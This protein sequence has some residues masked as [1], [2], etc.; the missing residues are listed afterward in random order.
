MRAQ[1]ITDFPDPTIG[2]NGQP[3]YANMPMPTDQFK[4]AVQACHQYSPGANGFT[5]PGASGS[6][7][8]A[9]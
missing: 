3:G 1:G 9:S 2:S 5:G 4:A 6:S 8:N 7:G